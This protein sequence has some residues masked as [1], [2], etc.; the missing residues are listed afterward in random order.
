[1]EQKKTES[2]NDY[3]NN[4]ANK[5]NCSFMNH[6][7]KKTGIKKNSILTSS[8]THKNINQ[9]N[10][11]IFND[12]RTKQNKINQCF[13]DL[14]NT[15]KQKEKAIKKEKNCFEQKINTDIN[16]FDNKSN[17]I[18]VNKNRKIKH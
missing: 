2:N 8:N 18:R 14:M 11:T 12:S 13:L 4:Y 3:Y 16:D 7:Y 6:N 17:N 1:M 15:K 5:E 10:L 9:K